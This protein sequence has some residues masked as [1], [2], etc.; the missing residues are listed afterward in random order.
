[1]IF[2]MNTN[3]TVSSGALIPLAVVAKAANLEVWAVE[4]LLVDALPGQSG[5]AST[6]SLEHVRTL[7]RHVEKRGFAVM[8]HSLRVL[9]S[10]SQEVPSHLLPVHRSEVTSPAPFAWQQRADLQ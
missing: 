1:M 4:K 5:T 3:P 10:K 6:M 8:A 9:A 7:A 2:P